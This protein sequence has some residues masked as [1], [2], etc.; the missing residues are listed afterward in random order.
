AE[1]NH[2]LE[3]LKLDGR[4][5]KTVLDAPGHRKR[6]AWTHGALAPVLARLGDTRGALRHLEEGKGLLER[7]LADDPRNLEYRRRRASRLTGRSPAL[8]GA[9]RPAE[10][11]DD[12]RQAL[13]AR[14]KLAADPGG[15]FDR[16]ELVVAYHNLAYQLASAGRSAEARRWYRASLA[17]R[18]DLA[19]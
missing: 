7:L 5:A 19:A 4:L 11:V 2:L 9:G 17:A 15:A 16:D 10:A 1:R 12:A 8:G 18:D 14:E 13:A 6:L 3:A